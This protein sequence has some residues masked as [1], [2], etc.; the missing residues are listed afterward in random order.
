MT[1][2]I[3]EEEYDFHIIAGPDHRSTELRR[4]LDEAAKFGLELLDDDECEPEIMEDD[5]IKIY[6]C[7]TAAPTTLRLVAA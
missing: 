1:L 5:S 4:V 6:L 7:P 3:D 2:V